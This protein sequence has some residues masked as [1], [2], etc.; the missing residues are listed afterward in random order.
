MPRLFDLSAYSLDDL[1]Q[2]IAAANKRLQGLRGKRIRSCRS[3]LKSLD[4]PSVPAM[5]G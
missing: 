3:S 1:N 5:R 2:L 4:L